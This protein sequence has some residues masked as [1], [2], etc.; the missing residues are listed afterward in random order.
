[1][2]GKAQA[3]LKQTRPFASLAIEAAINIWRTA[4]A[5][6]RDAEIALK[7]AD[8]THTQYNVLRILRGAG[9]AGLACSEIASRMVTRDPD[10][11]RLLDRLEKE[12]LVRRARC[13]QDRRVVL[14]QITAPG[15]KLLKDLDGPMRKA[16]E[17]RL[18][19]LGSKRLKALISL[20]E[21]VRAESF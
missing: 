3:E 5:L 9:P 10:I 17:R 16:G 21:E 12:E 15:L 14:T 1:M 11:T 4:D 13:T 2:T 8:I 6:L 18:R 19:Q 20:L 7:P